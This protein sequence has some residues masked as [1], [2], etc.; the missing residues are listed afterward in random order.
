MVAI[1][2]KLSSYVSDGLA[3]DWINKKLYW[4][5]SCTDHL[6]V[7][8]PETGHRKILISTGSGSD[9]RDIVVDPTTRYIIKGN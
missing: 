9:P 5:D 3:W 8:D 2:N 4:V 6:E 1:M 7:Y